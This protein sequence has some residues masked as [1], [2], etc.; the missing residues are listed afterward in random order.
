MMCAIKTENK[1]IKNT[2]KYAWL[3]MVLYGKSIF[4]SSPHMG[5]QAIGNLSKQPL[6]HILHSRDAESPLSTPLKAKVLVCKPAGDHG[7]IGSQMIL[8]SW[9]TKLLTDSW[10]N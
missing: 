6:H 5:V 8:V 1:L 7:V 9:L 3:L 2:N 4:Q 10:P